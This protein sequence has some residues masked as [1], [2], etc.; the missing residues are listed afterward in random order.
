MNIHAVQTQKDLASF[1][2]VPYQLYRQDPIWVPPLRDEQRG[3]F[4]PK[5]NP[6]L[7]HCEWQLFLLEDQG[8][9]VGRITSAVSSVALGCPIALGYVRR[10]FFAPGTAV[11]VEDARG[12]LEAHVAELPFVTPS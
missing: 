1:L 4:D 12:A 6:L 5:R 10:E 8:R 2:G 3:Q 7:D 9:P 11:A